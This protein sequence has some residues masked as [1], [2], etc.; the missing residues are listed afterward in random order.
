MG[1]GKKSI[2][3][4]NIISPNHSD[5]WEFW[6]VFLFSH[7]LLF[8]KIPEILASESL[9]VQSSNSIFEARTQKSI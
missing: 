1:I 2:R 6:F 9:A 5:N 7:R 3:K 8:F 4:E